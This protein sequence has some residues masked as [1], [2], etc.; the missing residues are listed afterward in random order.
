MREKSVVTSGE[1]VVNAYNESRFVDSAIGEYVFGDMGYR[2]A[3]DAFRRECQVLFALSVGD[4][5][6][7]RREDMRNYIVKI[8]LYI[9]L[10]PRDNGFAVVARLIETAAIR[11]DMEL[12]SVIDGFA[13]AHGA[14]RAAVERIVEKNFDPY[15]AELVDRVTT[16][17]GTQPFTAKDVL[18]DI[19]VFVRLRYYDGIYRDERVF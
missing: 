15:D 6:V 3:S 19:A 12:E 4:G 14:D 16:L 5:L 11:A 18:C 9:G 17:I 7:E 1:K 10:L 13:K 8:L 2:K